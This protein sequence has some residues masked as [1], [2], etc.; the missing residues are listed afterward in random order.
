[1]V[2]SSLYFPETEH[3]VI[4]SLNE[5]SDHQL[6]VLHK[7]NP[8]QGKYFAAIFSRYHEMIYTL[9]ISSVDFPPH[10][11]FFFAV[12][13]ERIF[14]QLG[15]LVLED[16]H[17]P[18][19]NS[20]QNWLIYQTALS[21]TQIKPPST[22]KNQQEKV[23]PPLWCYL[24]VAISQLLPLWRIILM[25]SENLEWSTTRITAYLQAEGEN[26][27]KEQVESYLE[28]AKNSIQ[29][30]LPQDIREIYLL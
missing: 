30:S 18:E 5:Y 21:L 3:P 8:E 23:S 24:R 25:M 28:Q 15:D 20:L 27:T 2:S 11:D 26:I 7:N 16:S 6:L 22:L 9:I 1:M 14:H 19:L 13:W 17:S 10:A 29:Q 12:T 4:A